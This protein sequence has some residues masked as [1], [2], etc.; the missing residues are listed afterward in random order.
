MEKENLIPAEDPNEEIP[1][2]VYSLFPELL[3]EAEND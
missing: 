2:A 3:D 1:E